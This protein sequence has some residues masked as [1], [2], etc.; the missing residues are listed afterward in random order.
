VTAVQ[1]HSDADDD[2]AD[3]MASTASNGGGGGGK[4][5]VSASPVDASVAI[6]A[7]GSAV[8]DDAN[9]SSDGAAAATAQAPT[10]D[11]NADGGDNADDDDADDAEST[12]ELNVKASKKK[13][14]DN[15]SEEVSAKDEDDEDA[16]DDDN[17]NADDANDDEEE[18]EEEEEEEDEEEADDDDEDD[19]DAD[20]DDDDDDEAVLTTS[21]RKRASSGLG[22]K[23]EIVKHGFLERKKTG[24]RTNWERRFF[25]IS[26]D[27]V[28][29]ERLTDTAKRDKLAFHLGLARVALVPNAKKKGTFHVEARDVATG[30]LHHVQ[31]R[32]LEPDDDETAAWIAACV[33]VGG[34]KTASDGSVEAVLDTNMHGGVFVAPQ[35][36]GSKRHMKH[37]GSGLARA[38]LP[39]PASAVAVSQALTNIAKHDEDGS[40]APASTS[41]GSDAPGE[42]T[43]TS[44]SHTASRAA[45]NKAVREAAKKKG[46]TAS[47]S[48]S[49]NNSTSRSASR[50]LGAKLKTLVSGNA[51]STLTSADVDAL[52]VGDEE[53]EVADVESARKVIAMLHK[54]N[55]TLG[56]YA[57]ARAA[58]EAKPT[59]HG[60][61]SA[62]GSPSVGASSSVGN[63]AKN[64]QQRDL[65]QEMQE[66]YRK[67]Q[68]DYSQLVKYKHMHKKEKEAHSELRR[69][70][71]ELTEVSRTR[72]ARLAEMLS[73]AEEAE[74][75]AKAAEL[76]SINGA[77]AIDEA[78]VAYMRAAAAEQRLRTIA[79]EALNREND[80]QRRLEA[81]SRELAVARE[82]ARRAAGEIVELARALDQRDSSLRRLEEALVEAQRSADAERENAASHAAEASLV[83]AQLRV[84]TATNATSSAASAAAGSQAGGVAS[85]KRT[86]R[87]HQS[88]SS[89]AAT[90]APAMSAT[91][92]AAA[93]AV[94]RRVRRPASGTEHSDS[95]DAAR[96]SGSIELSQSQ[97]ASTPRSQLQQT[98]S[99]DAVLPPVAAIEPYDAD[100]LRKLLAQFGTDEK[101]YVADLNNVLAMYHTPLCSAKNTQQRP[102]SVDYERIMFQN[103]A[104][105]AEFAGEFAR[106]FDSM[107]TDAGDVTTLDV[108]AMF[109]FMER[110]FAMYSTYMSGLP[111][112]ASAVRRWNSSD[113]PRAV[114]VPVYF[115]QH[116]L[117]RMLRY[118]DFLRQ[119]VERSKAGSA[120]SKSAENARQRFAALVD[121]AQRCE[122]LLARQSK[123]FEFIDRLAGDDPAIYEQCQYL[124]SGDLTMRVRKKDNQ[125]SSRRVLV[126]LL[127]DRIV[128]TVARAADAAKMPTPNGAHDESSEEIAE[129]PTPPTGDAVPS[130]DEEAAA[131]AATGAGVAGSRISASK[132]A[133]AAP[134]GD[135]VFELKQVIFLKQV[136][137]VLTVANFGLRLETDDSASPLTL[138]APRREV[139][140]DWVRRI[141]EA[142]ASSAPVLFDDRPPP[143][144][145]DASETDDAVVESDDERQLPPRPGVGD[146]PRDVQ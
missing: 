49:A 105:I 119:L 131:A 10:D 135:V 13:S 55:Q 121:A 28:L 53:L 97:S 100:A 27:G 35:S 110:K 123:M 126:W 102:L 16:A 76:L 14:D 115:L 120:N 127:R 38:S 106:N 26:G 116:P 92:A 111:K 17:D 63:S 21:E 146:S 8:D 70:N 41:E 4:A 50:S 48:N 34:V 33:K 93:S 64:E 88:M 2:D 140:S 68:E 36:D 86:A 1:V 51:T 20:D 37:S 113:E 6:K 31:L 66:N 101:K 69:V 15:E 11:N 98:Q 96:R 107:A 142:C 108:G 58:D 3:D 24:L 75:R 7:D 94:K 43:Q 114:Q 74:E 18:G 90:L 81:R 129:E 125:R 85:T 56:R 62:P 132:D 141:D 77:R 30:A 46:L 134:L 23:S 72:E 45:H 87:R 60:K 84:V 42:S 59:S 65:L 137:R 52:T 9:N 139:Q 89:N 57:R 144:V 118:G 29:H 145:E 128:V 80:F 54:R 95:D 40:D 5:I 19:E 133:P 82:H 122:T 83:R 79:H 143:P 104:E 47:S 39:R 138:Y 71:K 25:V 22:D 67:V 78:R 99:A 103:L 12:Q 112:A 44:G 124:H 117:R 32:P 136:R 130:D 91:V 109:T 73:R 61:G